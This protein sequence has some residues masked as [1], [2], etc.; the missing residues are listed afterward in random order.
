MS[1]EDIVADKTRAAIWSRY[2]ETRDQFDL[3]VFAEHLIECGDSRAMMDYG[4]F[5]NRSI[6]LA[7]Q[8][9]CWHLF[10]K[11]LF[12]N[13][14]VCRMRTENDE[15]LATHGE[16]FFT[17]GYR[18]FMAVSMD[19]VR[20]G[21]WHGIRD[22]FADR[23]HSPVDLHARNR[24]TMRIDIRWMFRLGVPA[25]VSLRGI[26]F[27]AAW[28][29]LR[30]SF[31]IE[32]VVLTEPPPVAVEI[33]PRER[34]AVV[35]VVGVQG[36]NVTVDE[37]AV[38][39]T[40]LVRHYH[41]EELIQAALSNAIPNAR[42]EIRNCGVDSDRGWSIMDFVAGGLRGNG[43]SRFLEYAPQFVPDGQ[44]PLYVPYL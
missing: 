27:C 24:T 15:F 6:E 42:V 26:E 8:P 39:N 33:L 36:A 32:Y 16:W 19:T 34:R 31:P 12:P 30:R 38:V 21:G 7:N 44:Q 11:S 1:W 37:S 4:W 43:T 22:Y 28:E 25:W 9:K 5:V 40:G 13:C 3:G 35:E 14:P 17:P 29:W 10:A 2:V 41:N 20:R 18:L 23:T